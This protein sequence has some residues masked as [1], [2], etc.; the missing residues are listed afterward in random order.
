MDNSV[1][2]SIRTKFKYGTHIS[3]EIKNNKIKIADDGRGIPLTNAEG[4][5]ISQLELALTELR[6]GSNFNDDEGRN[7]LGMNGVGSSLTNI[8]STSFKAVVYD[9]KLKGVLTWNT[10]T[11]HYY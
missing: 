4:T 11:Q 8:F 1:D 10:Y 3:V 6:A 9:G 7:L 2:E 5:N